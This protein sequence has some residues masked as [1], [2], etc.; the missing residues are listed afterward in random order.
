MC[1][2][3]LFVYFG[4]K[5]GCHNAGKIEAKQWIILEPL[6]LD[7]TADPFMLRFQCPPPYQG[8]LGKI[9]KSLL[10]GCGTLQQNEWTHASRLNR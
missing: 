3:V 10:V 2:R 6:R 7:R 1:I 8:N 5:T 4:P 9:M